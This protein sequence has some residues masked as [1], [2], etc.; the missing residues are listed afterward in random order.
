MQTA[1][2]VAVMQPRADLDSMAYGQPYN[3]PQPVVVTVSDDNRL[4]N[5]FAS[6]PA[7]IDRKSVV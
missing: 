1:S 5:S 7:P 2:P 3:A 6:T 4:R